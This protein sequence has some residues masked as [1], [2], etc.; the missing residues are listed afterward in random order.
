[1]IPALKYSSTKSHTKILDLVCGGSPGRRTK[2]SSHDS[3]SAVML[4]TL[5]F[6]MSVNPCHHMII[7]S[8][9]ST[10]FEYRVSFLE[11]PEK[12]CTIKQS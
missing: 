3:T 2:S 11:V 6:S 12:A 1:M 10:V 7:E 5:A 4:V 9:F 8:T